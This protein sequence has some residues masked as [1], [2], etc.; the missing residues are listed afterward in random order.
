MVNC[1]VIGI[2]LCVAF[3]VLELDLCCILGIA[4]SWNWEFMLNS[5][6]NSL[7]VK[8]GGGVNLKFYSHVQ[9]WIIPAHITIS[10]SLRPWSVP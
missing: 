2:G 9:V 1:S 8:L 10:A 3:L 5:S 4:T 7:V 6:V